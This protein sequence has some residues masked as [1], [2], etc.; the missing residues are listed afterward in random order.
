MQH[1]VDR[2][3]SSGAHVIIVTIVTIGNR[4]GVRVSSDDDLFVG[5]RLFEALELLRR[6]PV[7]VR[8]VSHER[9]RPEVQSAERGE[10][11]GRSLPAKVR[12]VSGRQVR[13]HRGRDAMKRYALATLS[14]EEEALPLSVWFGLDS[15]RPSSSM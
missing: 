6:S 3:D 10:V 15:S 13:G 5:Q 8:A 2:A 9:R 7:R 12:R 4:V 1:E 14:D 11:P